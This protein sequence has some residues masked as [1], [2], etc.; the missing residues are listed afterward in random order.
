MKT[1]KTQAPSTLSADGVLHLQCP[2]SWE[3][4]SQQ[5][6]HY[7]LD[8][9]GC[10][11]YNDVEIRTYMLFRFCGIEVVKSH[12]HSVSCKVMLESGKWHFFDMQ[13]WQIQDMIGQ[14]SFVNSYDGF[15]RGL[16]AVGDFVAAD[17]QL[18]DYQFGWFLICEKNYAAYINTKDTKY[19]DILAQWLYMDGDIPVAK[20]GKQLECDAAVMM[21]AFLWFSCVKARYSKMFPHFYKPVDKIGGTYNFLESYNAQLRALTDGDVTKEEEVKSVGCLRALTELDAKTREAE[22]FKRKYGDK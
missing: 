6:L 2:R 14:L 22:E 10:G 17:E 4:L 9:L 1:E 8:L 11:L 3:E 16:E 21:S 19:L 18:S 15:G 13:D 5:Q 12:A 20:S 7:T